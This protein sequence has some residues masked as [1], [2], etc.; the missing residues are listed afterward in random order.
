MH[1]RK[2]T[3]YIGAGI[4]LLLCLGCATTGPRP[5]P[6]WLV[7]VPKQPAPSPL[8]QNGARQ[9]LIADL[10]QT[11]LASRY[12]PPEQIALLA[13]QLVDEGYPLDATVFLTAAS[14]TYHRQADFAVREA[15]R[16]APAHLANATAQGVDAFR[17]FVRGEYQTFRDL[18]FQDSMA[19]TLA[20]WERKKK[21]FEQV[22][23]EWQ[24]VSGSLGMSSVE[25]QNAIK[26]ELAK[27][28][29]TARSPQWDKLKYPDVAEALLNRLKSDLS[30]D[31]FNFN[32][33]LHLAAVPF[34]SY[35]LAGLHNA[36]MPFMVPVCRSIGLRFAVYENDV[37]S[38]LE[39]TSVNARSNAALILGL[40]GG[41]K[42]VDAI[43]RAYVVEK[44]AI[45]R[46]SMEFALIVAES[47]EN[48]K[49]TMIRRLAGHITEATGEENMAHLVLL[50]EWLPE[51]ALSALDTRWLHNVVADTSQAQFTRSFA[52]MTLGNIGSKQPISPDTLNLMLTLSDAE[53]DAF[54]EWAHN[55]VIRIQSINRETALSMLASQSAGKDA[56]LQRML[57]LAEPDDFAFWQQQT[58]GFSS[59]SEQGKRIVIWGLKETGKENAATFLEQM[60]VTHNDYRLDIAIAY[61][62]ISSI[63]KAQLLALAAKDSGVSG[64]FLLFAAKKRDEAVRRLDG[65]LKSSDVRDKMMGARLAKMFFVKEQ[66]TAL[67]NNVAFYDNR[68]YPNDA[69]LR[70]QQLEALLSIS[71]YQA[72]LRSKHEFGAPELQRK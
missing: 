56:L 51:A 16:T 36:P 22:E 68:Y 37:V 33:G 61:A 69:I 72:F 32:A 21:V 4:V 6:G 7:H 54:A 18:N 44:D 15:E 39:S 50:Y 23:R 63:S 49:N 43:S 19:F 28:L 66:K 26:E 11:Q 29:E 38:A 40:R 9:Q 24:Q 48:K 58:N 5:V 35:L 70:N 14:Y 1:N 10:N 12:I 20:L 53:D 47:D 67:Q 42:Y 55:A 3:L 46:W 52:L 45:V 27:K 31:Q 25:R 8:S 17:D 30:N 60:F 59:H 65:L 71:V 62:S 2:I 41:E 34:K 13:L 57:I 64:T